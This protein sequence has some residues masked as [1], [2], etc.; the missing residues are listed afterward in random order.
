MPPCSTAQSEGMDETDVDVLIAEE[1]FGVKDKTIRSGGPC[2]W[3][4]EPPGFRPAF[5]SALPRC[6]VG[7]AIDRG[8][9]RVRPGSRSPVHRADIIGERDLGHCPGFSWKHMER[10]RAAIH[11][12]EHRLGC[13]HSDGAE[14]VEPVLAAPPAHR[15]FAAV[16]VSS[17]DPQTGVAEVRAAWS[18]Y[19]W[20]VQA[21]RLCRLASDHDIVVTMDVCP[22]QLVTPGD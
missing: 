22:G 19:V 20:Y 5:R 4:H 2:D 9:R 6:R 1:V 3:R 15:E 11:R 8:R 10:A 21:E 13:G 17:F 16:P 7:R 12:S 14:Y 18:G